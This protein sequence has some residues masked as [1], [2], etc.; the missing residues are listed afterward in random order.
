MLCSYLKCR[1]GT[2]VFLV[3][4]DVVLYI[5]VIYFFEEFL[6]YEFAFVDV[7]VDLF[8][9]E[10]CGGQEVE[11]VVALVSFQDFTQLHQV[12]VGVRFGV[13]HDLT[14]LS[15]LTQTRFSNP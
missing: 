12:E 8:L 11:E 13:R 7:L 14:H 6:F 1:I 5:V 9:L 10:V 4:E 3:V 15:L 2:I